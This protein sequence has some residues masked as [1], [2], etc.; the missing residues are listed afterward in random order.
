MHTHLMLL[1]LLGRKN[2]IVS[3]DINYKLGIHVYYYMHAMF[4]T[5]THGQY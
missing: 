5:V 3:K 4:V 1:F 2:A